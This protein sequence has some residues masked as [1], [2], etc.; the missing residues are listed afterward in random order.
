MESN[1]GSSGMQR[2]ILDHINP[3]N[4]QMNEEQFQTLKY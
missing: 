1:Y 4:G 3:N 2:S